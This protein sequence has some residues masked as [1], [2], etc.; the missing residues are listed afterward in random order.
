MSTPYERFMILKQGL[1]KSN[2][3]EKKDLDAYKYNKP[4]S[5]TVINQSNATIQI[6][7]PKNNVQQTTNK[8]PSELFKQRNEA[9]PR[10]SVEQQFKATNF[11]GFSD[12][13]PTANRFEMQNLFAQPKNIKFY[14]NNRWNSDTKE[15]KEE[16]LIIFE[17]ISETHLGITLKK[18]DTKLKDII[19]N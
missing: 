17:I 10:K 13:K 7:E 9:D 1:N 8:E 19:K 5:K 12:I 14:G 2:D 4:M 6:Y 18:Y 15:D 3:K 11:E 16:K